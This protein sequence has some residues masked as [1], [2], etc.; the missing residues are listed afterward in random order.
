MAERV[1]S[2]DI[3]PM[4][5]RRYVEEN[6]SIDKMVRHYIALYQETL[7]ESLSPRAA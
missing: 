7:S 3:D 2:L 6:F 1:R 5:V 4:A